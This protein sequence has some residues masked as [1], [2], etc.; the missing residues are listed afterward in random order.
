MGGYTPALA[1]SRVIAFRSPFLTSSAQ[2][3]ILT[4]NQMEFS[5]LWNA[6]M[7][8]SRKPGDLVHVSS[9][10]LMVIGFDGGA[11][12]CLPTLYQAGRSDHLPERSCGCDC[13]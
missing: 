11:L 2:N 12:L 7:N 5:R 9:S 6:V 4:P 8:D 10:M 3:V 13:S 1:N